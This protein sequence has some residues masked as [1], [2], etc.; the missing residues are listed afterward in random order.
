MRGA[1]IK[2]QS[3]PPGTAEQRVREIRRATRKPYSAEE[4]IRI[5]LAGLRGEHSIAELCRR[6]GLAVTF[7]D[8]K[9]QFISEASV[10]RLLK[11]AA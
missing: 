7:T 2:P 10:Y 5:L 8:T 3:K 11:A 9:V 1:S 6:E 4:K